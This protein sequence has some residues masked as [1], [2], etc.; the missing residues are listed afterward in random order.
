MAA[1]DRTVDRCRPQGM[2]FRYIDTVTGEAEHAPMAIQPSQAEP[3]FDHR[4]HVISR[5]AEAG[6]TRPTWHVMIIAST[7]RNSDA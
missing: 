2:R 6:T 7:N 3:V 1:V 5:P 4:D